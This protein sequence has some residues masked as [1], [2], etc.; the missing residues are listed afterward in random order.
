MVWKAW[1]SVKIQTIFNGLLDTFWAQI[2][3]TADIIG[4]TTIE[5]ENR[6]FFITYFSVSQF[7]IR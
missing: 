2:G 1:S 7:L 5:V 3:C 6:L 4:S